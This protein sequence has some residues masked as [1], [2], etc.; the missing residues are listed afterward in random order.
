[1]QGKRW[2][3]NY[4]LLNILIII[5]GITLNMPLPGF[6]YIFLLSAILLSGIGSIHILKEKVLFLF[7]KNNWSYI[8]F[9]TLSFLIIAIKRII[10]LGNG[11]DISIITGFGEVVLAAFGLI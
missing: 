7:I 4:I 9:C 6:K 3:R 10:M 1:M 2:S 5:A 11:Q 8:L